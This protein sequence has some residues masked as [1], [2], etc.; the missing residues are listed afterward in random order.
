MACT[1]TYMPTKRVVPRVFTEFEFGGRFAVSV[2]RSRST[3]NV[4]S[5][6]SSKLYMRREKAFSRLGFPAI[7][8]YRCC[9]V[10]YH[11]LLSVAG[12]LL[13]GFLPVATPERE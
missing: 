12:K 4:L 1:Y 10:L 7:R 6:R 3:M 5:S 8:T 9:I 2:G 11:K 13:V